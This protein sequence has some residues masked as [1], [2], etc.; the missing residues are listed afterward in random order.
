MTTIRPAIASD[1]QALA[2]LKLT[3][4]RETFL[5]GFGIRY[6]PDDL[7][8]FE[9]NS[10]S[11]RVV[12]TELADPE[13]AT[14]VAERDGRLLAY[15][16]VGPSKLPHPDVRPGAGELYQLY[17]RGEAQGLG[18]GRSL[19]TIALDH[20]AATRPG[21]IWLDVWSG[22]LK[23]QAVYVARGF[24]KVGEYR[25]PVGSWYDDEFIFRCD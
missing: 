1:A 2:D 10:Y 19:L 5:D 22:N 4:F 9:A 20:L 13:R 6:P 24:A 16:Q 11:F 14:W 8:A 15:A 23:A 3:T 17:A 25:F 7:A 12:S 18:L 21:P